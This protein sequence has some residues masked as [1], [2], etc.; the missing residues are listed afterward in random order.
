MNYICF[1][2]NDN[3]TYTPDF[4]CNNIFYEVKGY[5]HPHSKMKM[6]LFIEQYPEH[7]LII[8]D[9]EYLKK[10]KLIK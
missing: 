10:L 3:N 8:V 1:I 9:R 2:L 5:L 4:Y 6:D 7:T